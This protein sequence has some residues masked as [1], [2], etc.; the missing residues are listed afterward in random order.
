MSLRQS[1]RRRGVITLALSHVNATAAANLAIA[2]TAGADN[3]AAA[4]ACVAASTVVAAYA[5]TSIG[6]L[7]VVTT[8]AL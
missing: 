4:A 2:H 8:G 5:P 7:V 6:L 1:A 3:V